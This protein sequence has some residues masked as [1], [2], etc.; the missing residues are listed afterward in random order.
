MDIMFFDVIVKGQE[1]AAA[2]VMSNYYA[3]I[4]QRLIFIPNKSNLHL[5][6]AY[7]PRPR[8]EQDQDKDKDKHKNKKKSKKQTLRN[9]TT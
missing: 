2:L 1:I 4:S 8:Q 6:K 5:V 3:L 9:S 7:M